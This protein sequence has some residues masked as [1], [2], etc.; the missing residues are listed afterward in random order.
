MPTPSHSPKHDRHRKLVAVCAL[1]LLAMFNANHA[2]ATPPKGTEYKLKAALIYKLTKFIEWPATA[3]P[4]SRHFTL[5]VL[6]DDPFGN[7]LDALTNRKVNNLP[8]RIERFS[9]SK[10]LSSACRLIFISE[11]KQAFVESILQPLAHA[12]VLTVGDMTSFAARGG[13]IQ[14]ASKGNHIRFKINLSATDLAG[15]KIAAPLL[16]LATIVKQKDDRQ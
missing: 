7:A 13:M 3:T 14:M 5:C 1:W 16:D 11:S 12:P 10:A 6:G 9:Q 4:T 2:V 15:L 8:I